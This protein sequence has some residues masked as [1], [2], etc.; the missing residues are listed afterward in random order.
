M[1]L[2]RYLS[3][4]LA[5]ILFLLSFSNVIAG[6]EI[7]KEILLEAPL[8]PDYIKFTDDLAKGVVD[9]NYGYIPPRTDLSHLNSVP[10]TSR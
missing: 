6:G 4:F 3:V 7:N 1:H 9:S 5:L 2:K 8:N 10:V